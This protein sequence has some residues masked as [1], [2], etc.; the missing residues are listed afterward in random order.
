MSS[1]ST[2]KTVAETA[3]LKCME[4][5]VGKKIIVSKILALNDEN[6]RLKNK[7]NEA[8]ISVFSLNE[9]SKILSKIIENNYIVYQNANIPMDP[10]SKSLNLQLTNFM[11]ENFGETM[12]LRVEGILND[13]DGDDLLLRELIGKE[14]AA[15]G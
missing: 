1:N 8:R 13:T 15:N 2:A 6:R 3:I 10:K 7:Y 11:K 9:I 12:M 4:S 5:E 14:G